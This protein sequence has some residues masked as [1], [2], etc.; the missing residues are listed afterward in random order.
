MN[1][2][3]YNIMLHIPYQYLYNFITCKDTLKIYNSLF[4][5]NNYRHYLY[6]PIYTIPTIKDYHNIV[7]ANIKKDNILRNTTK[8]LVFKCF[9]LDFLRCIP[10]ECFHIFVNRTEMS[11]YNFQ[12][13]INLYKKTI[14][15]IAN[16]EGYYIKSDPHILM[17][18]DFHLMLT[19]LSY[20]K[21]NLSI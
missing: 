12:F 11:L 7:Y 20:Y 9:N 18:N 16:N 14:V 17:D 4:F 21:Y 1:D 2:L 6:I 5:W 10:Y 19:K 13:Y 15:Y 3:L 8:V